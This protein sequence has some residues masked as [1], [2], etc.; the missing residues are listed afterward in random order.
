MHCPGSQGTPNWQLAEQKLPGLQLNPSL[1][2]GAASLV[3]SPPE[4]LRRIAS[5]IPPRG[6][7]LTNYYGMFSSHARDRRAVTQAPRTEPPA[8]AAA[9]SP[10][11][12]PRAPVSPSDR[13]RRLAWAELL[14]RTF[15]LDVLGCPKC[16]GHRRIIAAVTAP[17]AIKA[18]LAHLRLDAPA[19]AIAPARAPPS[20]QLDLP[21][22][23]FDPSLDPPAWAD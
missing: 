23:H 21:Q 16:G 14:K 10:P 6:V 22:N 18:I 9:R 12:P 4:F 20:A 3:L 7:H 17:S 8:P 11:P 5:L 13:A 2:G 19:P 1:H 15:G